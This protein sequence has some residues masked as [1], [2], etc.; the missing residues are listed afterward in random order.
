MNQRIT[1]AGGEFIVA[2]IVADALFDYALILSK[3]SSVDVVDVRT[4]HIDGSGGR[5]RMLIG[6]G[7]PL[8]AEAT[9]DHPEAM[10]S[11]PEDEASAALIR[12]RAA[13]LGRSPLIRIDGDGHSGL[14]S[15]DDLS[16]YDDL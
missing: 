2:D 4:R 14:G 1:Y 11:H 10:V 13:S 12:Y 15:Y 9:R 8:A 5:M 6:E 16:S 7:L 3:R